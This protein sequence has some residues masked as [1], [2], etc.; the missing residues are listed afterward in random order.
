MVAVNSLSRKENE[1]WNLLV[2]VLIYTNRARIMRGKLSRLYC[3]GQKPAVQEVDIA[4]V[5]DH[6]TRTQYLIGQV[7]GSVTFVPEREYC[8]IPR[9]RLIY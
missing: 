5:G 9:Y 8:F 7:G 1:S 4:S 6:G 2:T 3:C